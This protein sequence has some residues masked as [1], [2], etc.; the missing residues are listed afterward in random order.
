MLTLFLENKTN[1]HTDIKMNLFYAKMK[2][3]IK[4]EFHTNSKGAKAPLLLLPFAFLPH[5]KGNFNL[6]QKRLKS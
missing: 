3:T 4:Q 2:L 5:Y 6:S 1:S